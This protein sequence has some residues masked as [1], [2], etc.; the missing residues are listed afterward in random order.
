M[1]RRFAQAAMQ[2]L[3]AKEMFMQNLHNEV[4]N[5]RALPAYI[6]DNAVALADALIV[7]LA[8]K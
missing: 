2:G 5:E 8:S 3:L 6:A 4:K 7:A 1:R